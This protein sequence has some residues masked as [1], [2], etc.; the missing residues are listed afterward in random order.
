MSAAD[1]DT[2]IT[3]REWALYEAGKQKAENTLTGRELLTAI[4][5]GFGAGMVVAWRLFA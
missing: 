2:P 3:D 5:A 1:D 4:L